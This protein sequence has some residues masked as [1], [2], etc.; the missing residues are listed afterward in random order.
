MKTKNKIFTFIIFSLP[1]GENAPITLLAI[2]YV[3]MYIKHWIFKSMFNY[4]YCNVQ[5]IYFFWL[6]TISL[7]NWLPKINI[8][9]RNNYY[10]TVDTGN[11]KN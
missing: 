6:H 2:I 11:F 1:Q 9:Q 3:C 10:F 4:K 5:M 7:H 8:K